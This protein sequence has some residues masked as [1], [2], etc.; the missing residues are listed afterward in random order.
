MGAS[1]V[2]VERSFCALVHRGRER[3]APTEGA[4][5]TLQGAPIR[6]SRTIHQAL[7]ALSS[8]YRVLPGCGACAAT[9]SSGQAWRG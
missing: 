9:G 6:H 7:S 8:R 5:A 1:G 2:Q 3:R 4:E